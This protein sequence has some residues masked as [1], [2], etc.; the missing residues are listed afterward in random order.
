MLKQYLPIATIMIVAIV[1]FTSCSEDLSKVTPNQEVSDEAFLNNNH[2]IL[3]PLADS[4]ASMVAL[5]PLSGSNADVLIKSKIINIDNISNYNQKLPA[6][7]DVLYINTTYD[8]SKIPESQ[9]FNDALG[10][11][12]TRILIDGTPQSIEKFCKNNFPI[13]EPG[14]E[15]IAY[16][17]DPADEI[18]E[19]SSLGL[20]AYGKAKNEISVDGLLGSLFNT[21]QPLNIT[22]DTTYL[23]PLT[24]PNTKLSAA[25]FCDIKI[26]WRDNEQLW[27]FSDDVR[28]DHEWAREHGTTIGP[29]HN[30]VHFHNPSN[31]AMNWGFTQRVLRGP[32]GPKGGGA[33]HWEYF[34]V[35]RINCD[36][37]EGKSGRILKYWIAPSNRKISVTQN[38]LFKRSASLRAFN[39]NSIKSAYLDFA[40]QDNY[41][42]KKGTGWGIGGSVTVG[43]RAG[44]VSIESLT[45]YSFS[46]SKSQ[47]RTISKNIQREFWISPCLAR[48]AKSNY[49]YGE[50]KAFT[51]YVY[52]NSYIVGDV[53]F[54]YNSQ[55]NNKS[56]SIVYRMADPDKYSYLLNMNNGK[57]LFYGPMVIASFWY[58]TSMSGGSPIPWRTLRDC[59]WG[60][61]K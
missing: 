5:T 48:Q 4:V 22:A 54:P 16:F 60:K 11:F 55:L 39:I 27:Q 12:H 24:N 9:I 7:T 52:P 57:S 38:R 37:R 14:A 44:V 1:W 31:D 21:H 49:I 61:K 41:T 17:A 32:E 2:N 47:S 28:S 40:L 51:G 3:N 20:F 53:S 6:N 33:S 29:D 43:V 59:L 35:K 26:D 25:P 42:V 13:F 15:L 50:L 18:N 45:E 19:G 34:D 58:R 30:G 8:C 10:R 56:R 46:K 36:D 23:A